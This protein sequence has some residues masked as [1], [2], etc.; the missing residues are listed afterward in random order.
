M[1]KAVIAIAILETAVVAVF[2]GLMLQPSDPLG[3][4]IGQ[5]M[6]KL[7][8]LPFLAMV[9]PGLVLGIAN[10]WLPAALALVLLAVPVSAVLWR[11]A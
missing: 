1:R 2:A 11:M 7:A 6:M 3:R 5:G 9:L 10:R 4:A 8:A